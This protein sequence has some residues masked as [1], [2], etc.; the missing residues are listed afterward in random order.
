MTRSRDRGS[1]LPDRCRRAFRVLFVP[2]GTRPV[3]RVTLAFRKTF[4]HP[5]RFV[6]EIEQNPLGPVSG[7][8]SK[9]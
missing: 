2:A 3:Y 6:A 5:G 9:M 7:E 8:L 4:H 1:S